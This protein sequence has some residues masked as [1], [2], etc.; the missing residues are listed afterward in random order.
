M[1]SHVFRHSCLC[2]AKKTSVS[3]LSAGHL[4]QLKSRTEWPVLYAGFNGDS[5]QRL[6]F[7]VVVV[8]RPMSW[9][10]NAC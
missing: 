3:S 8:E 10:F 2:G 1:L 9:A 4:L 6:V 7:R 5:I